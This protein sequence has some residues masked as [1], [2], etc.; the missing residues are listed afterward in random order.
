MLCK[1]GSI[2]LN[3][4]IAYVSQQAWIF[5]GTAKDNILFGAPYVKNKFNRIVEACALTDDF[6]IMPNGED[7][8]IGENGVNLSGG[9]KQRINLAR[10]LY[11]RDLSNIFLL[12]DPLSAV[13]AKV[14]AHIF[15]R[16]L[17]E[18]LAN[19]TVVLVTHGQQV[20]VKRYSSGHNKQF[21]SF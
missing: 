19:E 12:D 18:E 16:A 13:D 10:A 4:K 11:S 5:S 3:G 20:Q 17:L 1:S 8:E 7:S 21:H 9:Q 6:R 2:K 15:E 14:A